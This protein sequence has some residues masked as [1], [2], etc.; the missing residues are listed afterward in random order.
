MTGAS[1]NPFVALLILGA[2]HGINPGMGWLFAVAR[3]C[4]AGDR[5]KGRRAVWGSLGPLAVGHALAIGAAVALAATLGSIVPLP[6]LRGVVGAGLVVRGVTMVVRHRH[7]RGGGMTVGAG[8][9][10]WWSF[11]MASAHGAGLMALP[12]ALR[13]SSP[14]GV[15]SSIH[16]MH[17]MTHASMGPQLDINTLAA[18]G[19]HAVGYLLVSGLLAFVVYERVGV[20]M[21]RSAWIN[22]D[23]LWA[24]ALIVTGIATLS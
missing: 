17:A 3:G 20:R 5:A 16:G 4:Q 21:L 22:I 19:A 7:P 1:W 23:W 11:L 2:V 14:A 10:A 18:T 12:F 9:L 8:G 6:F 24:C 13:M 15:A